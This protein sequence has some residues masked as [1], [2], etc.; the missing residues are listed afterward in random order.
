LQQSLK[1]FNH[2]EIAA[3][4]LFFSR[5][6]PETVSVPEL[7]GCNVESSFK[8]LVFSASQFQFQ[9]TDCDK[10]PPTILV[11]SAGQFL[12]QNSQIATSFPLTILVPFSRPVSVSQL[13]DCHNLPCSIL[14]SSA[15]QFLF[16]SSQIQTIFGSFID[17]LCCFLR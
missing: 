17:H 2:L 4:L 15:G 1:S 12:F 3:I 7:T 13:A 16:H 6:M 11:S 8:I 5:P 10:L 9:L 14:I